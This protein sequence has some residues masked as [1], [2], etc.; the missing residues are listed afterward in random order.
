MKNLY[1]KYFYILYILIHNYHYN[2][3]YIQWRILVY[4]KVPYSDKIY[5]LSLFIKKISNI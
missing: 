5:I 1:T 4:K 2:K 3:M